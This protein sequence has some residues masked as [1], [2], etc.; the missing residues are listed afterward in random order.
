MSSK[1]KQPQTAI[2]KYNAIQKIG[3]EVQ[4]PFYVWTKF[5]SKQKQ[6]SLV[7]T[8]ISLGEDYCRIDEA[9]NAIKWYVTQLGGKVTWET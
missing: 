4:V 5:G 3:T 7:G 8:D 6:I 2:E 1:K 9:R